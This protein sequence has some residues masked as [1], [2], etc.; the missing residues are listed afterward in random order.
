MTILARPVR[1]WAHL[2]IMVVGWALCTLAMVS[3][4]RD[5]P[6]LCDQLLDRGTYACVGRNAPGVF[7]FVWLST[8]VEWLVAAVIMWPVAAFRMWRVLTVV[9]CAGAL[10][11][12]LLFVQIHGGPITLM[13]LM[14]LWCLLLVGALH[15][16]DA[17]VL[18]VVRRLRDGGDD[19]ANHPWDA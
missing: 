13:H 11:V 9:L 10:S 12:P 16:L 17:V 4:W 18:A 1:I 8:T 6:G 2:A 3:S 14:G 15:A 5:D 7:G 19:D